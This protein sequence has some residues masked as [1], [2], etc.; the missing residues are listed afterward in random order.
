M[1]K[2]VKVQ[3]VVRM[4][5]ARQNYK[6][7]INH[8]QNN[9][10]KIVVIQRAARGYHNRKR[11]KKRKEHFK[12]NEKLIEKM[13][14]R[15]KANIQRKAYKAR[16]AHFASHEAA[17]I[18]LQAWARGRIAAKQYRKLRQGAGATDVRAL[19]Q[20]L[21]LLDDGT[22]DLEEIKEI[23]DLRKQV[24]KGIRDNLVAEVEVGDLDSKIALIVKNRITLEEVAGFHSKDMRQHLANESAA[25]Q[26]KDG[27]FTLKGNDREV[28]EKRKKYEELFYLLQTQ[29]E[30][31]SS[32]MFTLN[33]FS[34]GNV[35][36]FLE[37][38][39]LSLYG[40]AQ[41]P[42]E[43]YLFLQLIDSCISVELKDIQKIEEFWRDNPMFVKLVLQFT[44]GAKERQYLRDL[45]RGPINLILGSDDL[46]LETEPLA[47]YKHLIREEELKTGEKSSKPY[48]I[49]AQDAAANPEVQEIQASRF[50]RL[51]KIT[52]SLLDSI[53][54]S[55]NK[56]PY[57][58]RY[59]AMRIKQQVKHKFLSLSA[60][61]EILKIVGNLIYYRYINPAIVYLTLTQCT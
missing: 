36:K 34:A 7:Q 52:N 51:Q 28:K 58:I 42:R 32:L 24:V 4:R 12:S 3:S 35:T 17:I 50:R 13:Q 1:D 5:N 55:L 43:E 29:P 21:N 41:N 18:K 33:K 59:I 25:N 48:E 38:I 6:K 53:L 26:L 20:Y 61:A 60:E 57:G 49:T 2:I 31:L 45:L 9:Q 39:V 19:Q 8:Y 56:M 30:Y 23:E 54:S 16:L 15:V 10:D 40:Y 22:T 14:A 11:L 44:R 37:G 47:I 46:E 27:I